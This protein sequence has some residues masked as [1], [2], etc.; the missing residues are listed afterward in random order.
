MKTALIINPRA[1]S[2]QTNSEALLAECA[3]MSEIAVWDCHDPKVK[4]RLVET[5]SSEGVG[6]IIAAGGDGTIHRVV[7][8]L[9]G[10]WDEFKLGL[11]PLGTGNDFCR[12][13]G[14]PLDPLEALRLAASDR[15]TRID[16]IEARSDS[17][18]IEICVNHASAGLG[19][20]I[21]NRVD[22]DTKQKW[23]TLSYLKT[24][25]DV[26][27]TEVPVFEVRLELDGQKLEPVCALNLVVGNGRTAGGGF[28][29][30]PH[31]DPKDRWMDVV[32]VREASAL[33][34]A[35]ITARLLTGDY[36]QSDAV[37]V[38]RAK[39]VRVESDPP[40]HFS[41]DGESFA[42][43]RAEFRIL[44]GALRVALNPETL[45]AAA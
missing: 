33:E 40:M 44:P 38:H 15:E 39:Q 14:I 8:Q 35:G 12:T 28:R 34:I 2:F 26:A 17:G 5:A 43:G 19:G 7:N 13:L 16:L 20:E 36:T 45:R 10:H 18:K 41:A 32:L 11:I 23:K 21:Q 37:T 42:D 27:R 24:A 3:R 6:T 9:R 25:A 31:A 1:G 29:V 22:H 30:A 4:K